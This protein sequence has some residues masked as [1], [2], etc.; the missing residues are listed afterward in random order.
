MKL[1]LYT[2]AP[3]LSHHRT[4]YNPPHITFS[5]LL[6]GLL[7]IL[8]VTVFAQSISGYTKGEGRP[9]RRIS[10][11]LSPFHP[12]LV[13]RWM[14]L[15]NEFQ[16]PSTAPS[17]VSFLRAEEVVFGKK[18]VPFPTAE[19]LLS[20]KCGRARQVHGSTD[21]PHSAHNFGG[22]GRDGRRSRRQLVPREMPPLRS[23]RSCPPASPQRQ[24]FYVLHCMA[25]AVGAASLRHMT[26]WAL[27]PFAII[28]WGPRQSE[29]A[30]EREDTFPL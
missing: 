22:H 14:A 10:H 1:T 9:R 15:P 24:L 8:Y 18:Q 11:L 6:R 13:A 21:L 7:D 23:R 4:S 20:K 5:A 12:S 16:V 27:V 25:A 28:F 30:N 2:P 26:L 19:Y 29:R 17:L 3:P